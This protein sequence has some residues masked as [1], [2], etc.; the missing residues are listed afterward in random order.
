MIL[1]TINKSPSSSNAFTNCLKFASAGSGVLL[2]EDAVYAA[3]NIEINSKFQSVDILQKYTWY[4]LEDDLL[5]RG[6]SE[7]VHTGFKKISYAEFVE[8]SLQ[9]SKVQ[10][11]S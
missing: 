4:V 8:L 1:H 7:K 2:L 5:A 3:L 6:V 9:Y 10:S 11:W